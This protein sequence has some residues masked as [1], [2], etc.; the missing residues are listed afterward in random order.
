MLL[1]RDGSA[2][3]AGRSYYLD[4]D[5]AYPSG[6]ARI[7]VRVAFGEVLVLAL[8]DT[9]A[10][11][12]V[13]NVEVAEDLELLDGHGEPLAMSTRIGRIE[14]NLVRTAATLVAEDGDSVDVDSTVFVSHEW[15]QPTVIGYSGLLERI[16]FAID[17]GTKS[18]VFGAR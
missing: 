1:W 8:L 15:R 7:H 6:D 13:L 12:S 11:W 18:F 5:P 17:P 14:G 16:R 9:G 4:A 2:F 3:A 10:S